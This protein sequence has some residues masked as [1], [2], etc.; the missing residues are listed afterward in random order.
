MVRCTALPLLLLSACVTSAFLPGKPVDTDDAPRGDDTDGPVDTA[1]PDDTDPVRDTAPDDSDTPVDDTEPVDTVVSD[2]T[3]DTGVPLGGPGTF[4]PDRLLYE[5][6]LAVDASA[7]MR[8]FVRDGREVQPYLQLTLSDG[9]DAC[10]LKYEASPATFDWENSFGSATTT[11]AWL[12]EVGFDWPIQF[13]FGV[14]EGDYQGRVLPGGRCDD[15]APGYFDPTVFAWARQ[16]DAWFPDPVYVGV[17]RGSLTNA[18]KTKAAADGV[19]TDRR[20]AGIFAIPAEDFAAFDDRW[21]H[22]YAVWAHVDAAHPVG[23]VPPVVVDAQG[24]PVLQPASGASN[25]NGRPSEGWF[26]VV[27]AAALD[28]RAR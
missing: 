21:V 3:F 15:L 14:D 9:T 26:R 25:G 2:D 7:H 23:G 18:A 12:V 20:L 5:A 28:V 8:S 1:W 16:A 13:G 27:G 11:W 10:V 22:A 6:E 24:D 4:H 19:A 17:G